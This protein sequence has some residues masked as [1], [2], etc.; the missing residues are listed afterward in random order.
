PI[1]VGME[2]KASGFTLIELMIVVAIVGILS[3]VMLPAV[4]NYTVRSKIAEAVLMMAACRTTVSEVFQA[5]T[6]TG[7]ANNWGC[8]EN[9]ITTKYVASLNTTTDGAIVVTLQN[10]GNEVDGRTIAMVP[11]KTASQA[12]TLADLGTALYG[13][14]CGSGP[15]TLGATYLPGSCRGT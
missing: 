5:R 11:M 1:I 13:W 6:G 15:T 9:S 4:Q 12:A 3:A 14:T 7:G 8:G 10:V 2:R